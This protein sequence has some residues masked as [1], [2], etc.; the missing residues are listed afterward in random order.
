M[1]EEGG[2]RLISQA[3]FANSFLIEIQFP[4]HTF[5]KKSKHFI[6]TENRYLKIIMFSAYSQIFGPE[7]VRIKI[8]ARDS[9]MPVSKYTQKTIRNYLRNRPGFSVS[10]NSTWMLHL[11]ILECFCKLQGY[12]ASRL[13]IR[14]RQEYW[15]VLAQVEVA[16]ASHNRNR[17]CTRNL[18]QWFSTWFKPN[19]ETTG[20]SY[21]SGSAGK[22]ISCAT[23][24]CQKSNFFSRLVTPRR[25]WPVWFARPRKR[26]KATCYIFKR[27]R[28]LQKGDFNRKAI[29]IRIT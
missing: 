2:T 23:D 10:L 17:K 27:W 20:G 7:F 6:E 9:I 22:E 25:G 12:T 13:H 4:F 5:W 15:P 24:Y 18:H 28:M 21:S 8:D 19:R 14:S 3:A 29:M 1:Y 11:C 16:S 26:G